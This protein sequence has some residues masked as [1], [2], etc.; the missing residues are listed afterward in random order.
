MWARR[1][2]LEMLWERPARLVSVSFLATALIGAIILSLPAATIAPGG[3]PFL[4]AFFTA[5]SAVC[6]T[7]L[8]VVDTATA[9]TPWGW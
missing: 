6:V 4:D 3:L 2:V 5:T 1:S 8:I 9:Y 7:G